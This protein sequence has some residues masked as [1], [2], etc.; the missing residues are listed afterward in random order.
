MNEQA[1]TDLAQG[2]VH[3]CTTI[4]ALFD[5]RVNELADKVALREKDFGC[6]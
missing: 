5:K 3:G 4:S 1:H 6:L 2:I